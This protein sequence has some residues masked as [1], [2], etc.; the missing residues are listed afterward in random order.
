MWHKHN[1][2]I[3]LNE[4][5]FANYTY[6]PW[7]FIRRQED[8]RFPGK[9]GR[10]IVGYLRSVNQSGE[11]GTEYNIVVGEDT[12]HPR[13]AG[14]H[15]GKPD[16]GRTKIDGKRHDFGAFGWVENDKFSVLSGVMMNRHIESDRKKWDAQ[17]YMS[18]LALCFAMSELTE[19]PPE[20]SNGPVTGRLELPNTQSFDKLHRLGVNMM[21]KR[22]SIG[23]EI[24][25]SQAKIRQVLD[26]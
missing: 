13:L 2:G 17:L 26:L 3:N 23:C 22:N 18:S 21:H 7:D 19:N 11:A 1:N 10:P 14:I 5:Y 25:V 8:Y 12:Y 6:Y 9:S 15:T 20:I 16:L 4:P 24:K